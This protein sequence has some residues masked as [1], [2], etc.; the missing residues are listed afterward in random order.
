MTHIFI[1]AA[2]LGLIGLIVW[3]FWL[4]QPKQKNLLSGE[5]EVLVENGVYEPAHI[6]VPA[7]KAFAMR[8]LRKD[9][10]SCAEQ[11]LFPDLAISSNLALNKTQE[12]QMPALEP[13]RYDFHC[14]MQMYRGQLEAK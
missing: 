13:G 3:W 6:I 12:I 1:N 8:F 4:Y 9:P 14:Q 11:V 7:H 10:S 5:L 2:G